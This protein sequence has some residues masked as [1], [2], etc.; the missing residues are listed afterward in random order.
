[1]KIGDKVIV[2]GQEVEII[3]SSPWKRRWQ[4]QFDDGYV[5]WFREDDL[6]PV[7]G[8]PEY[9]GGSVM[10][11][12]VGTVAITKM[13]EGSVMV[14]YRTESSYASAGVRDGEWYGWCDHDL[15]PHCQPEVVQIIKLGEHRPG[16]LGDEEE[17]V[18]WE[19]GAGQLHWK[20]NYGVEI[21]FTPGVD[22]CPCS[23]NKDATD[24]IIES[25]WTRLGPIEGIVIGGKVYGKD[26]G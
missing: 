26:G 5:D 11:C 13:G 24:C 14:T 7:P 17:G 16:P 15:D 12:P 9:V 25:D 6:H 18:V 20:D 3:S 19:D 21:F 10:E 22:T 2:N 23:N 1:M 8:E 4:V